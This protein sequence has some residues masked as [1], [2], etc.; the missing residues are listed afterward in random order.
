MCKLFYSV[1]D[2]NK[3]EFSFSSISVKTLYKSTQTGM[4]FVEYF[5]LSEGD[6]KNY[7]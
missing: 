2:L 1:E 4:E 5:L 6:A 7:F 3:Q